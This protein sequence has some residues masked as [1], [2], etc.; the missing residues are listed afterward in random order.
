MGLRKGVAWGWA[1]AQRGA[2]QGHSSEGLPRGVGLRWGVA[3][4]SAGAQPGAAQ[5]HSSEGLRRGLGV[6]RC[7]GLHRGA[8]W[9]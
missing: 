9:G 3:R 8:A 1:G 7:V 6:R 2:A 5:G 4:G